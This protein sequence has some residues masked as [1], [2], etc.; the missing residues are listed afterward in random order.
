M[1]TSHISSL[2]RLLPPAALGSVAVHP[3][4]TVRREGRADTTRLPSRA[5]LLPRCRIPGKPRSLFRE[6][7]LAKLRVTV[8][9]GMTQTVAKIRGIKE[10]A[11]TATVGA[12]TE[13]GNLC[14]KP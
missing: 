12:G 5:A 6:R 2:D 13:A 8:A 9:L 14:G 4:V 11:L 3:C 10:A 7:N 1:K